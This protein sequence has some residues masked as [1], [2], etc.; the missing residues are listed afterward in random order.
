MKKKL[1]SFIFALCLIIPC[2]IMLSA[3]GKDPDE[4]SPEN[5]VAVTIDFSMRDDITF[6]D[7]WDIDEQTNTYTITYG[8]GSWSDGLFEVVATT[9]DGNTRTLQKATEQN[10]AGYKIATNI[11]DQSTWT[12]AYIPAGTYTFKLYC[13]AFNNGIYKTEACEGETYTIIVNKKVLDFSEYNGFWDYSPEKPTNP[14]K[15]YSGEEQSIDIFMAIYSQEGIYNFEK[16]YSAGSVWSATNVGDYT[17]KIKYDTDENN[18]TYIGLPE[19]EFEW[20][21]TK[22]TYSATVMKYDLW[23]NVQTSYYISNGQSVDILSLTSVNASLSNLAFI[24][25]VGF[26]VNGEV[27]TG[28]DTI[29]ITEAGTY[30]I[31]PIFEQTDTHNYTVLNGDDYPCSFTVTTD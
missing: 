18:Y 5:A 14:N 8:D 19:K 23:G 12:S 28:G 13:D 6:S 4:P 10:P 29:T 24:R 25:V 7:L 2:G 15:E 17:A 20:H 11:P 1:L 9:E 3:C 31:V 26:K 30:E 21:I 22:K 16:D 27:W